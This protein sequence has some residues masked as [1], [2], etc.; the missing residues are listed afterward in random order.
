MKKKFS[1]IF[2]DRFFKKMES[3]FDCG[4]VIDVHKNE[5]AVY[6]VELINVNFYISPSVK[7]SEGYLFIDVFWSEKREFPGNLSP[8]TPVDFQ[9][10]KILK[11]N[12]VNGSFRFRLE[13]LWTMENCFKWKLDPNFKELNLLDPS[14]FNYENLKHQ[15]SDDDIIMK[16][17]E[18][19]IDEIAD[20][21]VLYL[22]PYMRQID[23]G[24]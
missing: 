19:V 24:T 9:G 11:S 18:L 8:M 3:V 5:W 22:V 10:L 16:N 14:S 12:P 17:I 15:D 13:R 21:M 1:K 2:K 6:V 4:K 23:S 7:V 20:K